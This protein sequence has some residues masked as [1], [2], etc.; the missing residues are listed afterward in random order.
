[1]RAALLFALVFL[2]AMTDNTRVT[3]LLNYVMASGTIAVQPTGWKLRLMQTNGSGSSAGTE[4]TG[5]TGYTT[6]GATMAAWTAA[7]GSAAAITGPVAAVSWTNS[8]GSAWT[9]VA[10]I[11]IWDTAGTPLRW[12]YGALS[13][14]SVTVNAG[15][16]LQFAANSITLTGT[17]W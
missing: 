16:T 17:S 1:V 14:G 5:A 10:G 4:L 2:G 8:G 12:F 7:S 15:N 6:L 3:N 13:G 11:E 9:A